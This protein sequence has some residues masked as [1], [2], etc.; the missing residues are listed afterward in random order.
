MSSIILDLPRY[1][2]AER[3]RP[4]L[5]FS[6]MS[7]VLTPEQ[8]HIVETWS[9][10]AGK[11]LKEWRES[12]KWSQKKVSEKVLAMNSLITQWE[13][14]SKRPTGQRKELLLALV[15]PSNFVRVTTEGYVTGQDLET[16]L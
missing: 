11:I 7:L 6:Q 2:V 12:R 1:R 8:Y 14:E 3:D 5:Y 15:A 4:V 16:I 9:P 10:G 13:N